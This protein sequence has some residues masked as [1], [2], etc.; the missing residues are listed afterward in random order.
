MR[1]KHKAVFTLILAIAAALLLQAQTPAPI[2]QTTDILA[3][4]RQTWKVLTR[5]NSNLAT[6][7]V[8]P[9]FHPG[10]DGRWPVYI[11]HTEDIR[12]VEESLRREM[13]AAG[14]KTLAVEALPEDLDSLKTQGLLYLPH[15]YVVPGGR[16][17]EMYGWDSYFIQVG[18]LRDKELTMAKNM[19]D[20]FLYEVRNYGK[21]LNA[22]RTYY[23][24]RSQPPF[25]TQ[26][27]LGVYKQ[28]HDRKYLEDALPQIEKYY[29]LWATEPHM[30][31]ETALARY[32]DFGEG[33]APEVVSAERDAAGRTHY[34][35]VKEYFKTHTI[36]DYDV[37]QYFDRTTDQL[38]PLFYKGDRSMRE[39]GFDP[40]NRFGP[41]N[42]DIIHY[43]PVCLNS[44]LYLMEMQ[45]G[46]IAEI[47]G[48][49]D[50]A[51]TWRDKAKRRGE[52][53]NSLMW[54]AKDGLYY[55]YDFVNKRVR[56]Y[57]FLTTFYPLW[58]GFA[59]KE[60]AARVV[61]NLPLFEK[62][63]GLQTSTYVSGNQWDS[64]F[65]WAPLQMI[66][67]EGLRRYG[68]VDD[69]ERISMKWLGLVR[70]EFLRQGFIV[71]KYDVVNGGSNVAAQIH[72]G[73]S[74]NQ[75]GFGWTNAVFTELYD[76][77]TPADQKKL[78]GQAGS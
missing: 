21:I 4:V 77:L 73:Y 66:A 34:E 75:A 69:A 6:A 50:E 2:A 37:N 30:T 62:I 53:V 36:T 39:S 20:D 68:Y 70:K 32:W 29:Q 7:A 27:V 5:S 31:P 43:D 42:I 63:G 19:A 78:L 15:P 28:T 51:A 56:H 57:P 12:L 38:T 54:D 17:N 23:M 11:S 72:F 71:E 58:A 18:L 59:T 76:E 14:F 10:P 24:T 33:P 47:V 16:F 1:T 49:K 44:L 61:K 8:D 40:S 9:K 13:P 67:V 74:A 60:Q 45:T 52:K 48:R 65:G 22:N 25:L 41:F 55:D 64:P 35:L 3:Y 46:D 26:M